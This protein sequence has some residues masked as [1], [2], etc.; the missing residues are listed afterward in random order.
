MS[1]DGGTVPEIAAMADPQIV[2]LVVG[3]AWP[4]VTAG[5][6]WAFRSQI[7]DLL[8]RLRHAG[9]DGFA[10]GAGQSA[11]SPDTLNPSLANPQH[12]LP[13]VELVRQR[14]DELVARLHIEES[15]L[16]DVVKTELAITLT[17]EHFQL[18]ECEIWRSQLEALH[19]LNNL[20]KPT[21]KK[22]LQPQFAKVKAD[23]PEIPAD[24]PFEQW[25]EYLIRAELVRRVD[26]DRVEITATGRDYLIT[27]GTLRIRPH[28]VF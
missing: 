2:D 14:I 3:V 25:L 4:A 21:E 6:V 13:T 10:F 23:N 7:R 19:T 17:R 22:L 5:I 26:D 24:F 18:V 11:P 27:R 8:S 15:K 12:P 1:P 20:R 9:K 16:A 28:L